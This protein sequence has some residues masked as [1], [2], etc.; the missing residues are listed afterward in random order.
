MPTIPAITIPMLPLFLSPPE[1][2][3]GALVVLA[4]ESDFF[5]ST[6]LG[7]NIGASSTTT[8]GAKDST[9]GGGISVTG[10]TGSRVNLGGAAGA[11]GGGVAG[12]EAS[13]ET[14]SASL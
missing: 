5:T 4:E 6:V 3:L 13:G 7:A 14:C 2:L 10:F 12:L 1:L 9:G 8:F 11:L